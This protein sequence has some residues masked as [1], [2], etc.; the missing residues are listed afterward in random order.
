MPALFGFLG[1]AV[2]IGLWYSYAVDLKNS[3]Q[4]ASM[5]VAMGGIYKLN[6]HDAIVTAA[7]IASGQADTESN[8]ATVYIGYSGNNIEATASQSMPVFLSA[9]LGQESFFSSVM[10]AAQIRQTSGGQY[11]AVISQ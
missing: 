11:Y 7:T 10:A 1:I 3:A 5:A 2:D 9:I 8:H 6:A 4:A